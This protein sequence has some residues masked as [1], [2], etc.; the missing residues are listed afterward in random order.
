MSKAPRR[1]VKLGKSEIDLLTCPPGQHDVMFFD[2]E[3]TGFALRVTSAG[4]KTFVFQYR[5]GARVHR[6]RL[7]TYGDLTPRQARKLA[8]TA[9]GKV[10]A[11]ESPVA[12][13]R[14]RIEAEA[15]AAKA[16]KTRAKADA[17]T[18]GILVG[19]WKE[20]GL[21]DRRERYRSEAVRALLVNFS[22]QVD[23]PADQVDETAARSIL[24]AMVKRRGTTMARRT[25]AYARAMYGWAV[26]RGLAATN[27]FANVAVEGREVR[28]ERVL[29]DAELGEVWRATGTLGWPYGPY[30]RFLLLTL[31]REA[32][33]AGLA[34]S[35]LSP[36]RDLWEIPGARTK[37]GK[38]H[39]VH[40]SEPARAILSAA[41][42][43]IIPGSR[44]P[45]E[46]ALV[47]TTTGRTPI[48]GFA[49]AKLRLDA[50]IAK[51][52]TEVAAKDGAVPAPLV[53][54]R[55]HDLRRTGVTALARLGVRWEV[56][57]KLLNHVS[58]AIQGI[59]AVYQRHDFLTEREVA[60]GVWAVHI[61]EA[62]G[63]EDG[64]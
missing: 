37:N 60:S 8:E 23:V 19:Q 26:K 31:Q 43:M 4:T 3:L 22:K 48:S 15:A 47:F 18:F 39:I 61:L 16:R 1:A 62:A 14:A 7:G 28:R 45:E 54:W 34:W 13:R 49:K 50:A 40:L 58:G 32:E 2:M 30:L 52:R 56:A 6:L 33:T 10:A 35:E 41:P 9:R 20:L 63:G 44:P 5:E 27:P 24:D 36:D 12:E 11:G 59:G 38:P 53:P 55:F 42:R 64:S 51:A 25:H 57:D 46:S 17:L 21:K 29:T